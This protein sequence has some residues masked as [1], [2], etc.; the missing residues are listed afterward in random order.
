MRTMRNL[1]TKSEFLNKQ[2]V[3]N[4]GLFQFLGKMFNKV[5]TQINKV[6]GGNLVEEIYQKYL[7]IIN[8]EF[9]KQAGVVLHLGAEEQL[10]PQQGQQQQQ[11]VQGQQKPEHPDQRQQQQQ[12]AQKQPE[13]QNAGY[14]FYDVDML[15]EAVGDSTDSAPI[16]QQQQEQGVGEQKPP[17]GE[18]KPEKEKPADANTKMSVAT[19][20]QKQQALQKILDLY[21][22]KALKEMDLVLQKMGGAEKNPKLKIVIDNKKDQFKLDYLNAEI[23]FLEKSG[24]K[25]TAN[26]IAVERNKLAKSLDTRWN[27]NVPAGTETQAEIDINGKKIKLNTPYQYNAGGVSKTIMITGKSN[28]PQKV[29]AKFVS[30]DP[31]FGGKT[32]EQE[33]RGNLIKTDF[34]PIKG[35]YKYF[36]TKRNAIIDVT[37]ENDTID[38]LGRIK[39]KTENGNIL[40]PSG[41]LMSAGKKVEQKT[42]PEKQTAAVQ[43]PA[44]PAPE[45]PAAKTKQ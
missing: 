29:K 5:K 4:E 36:S 13:K 6:K 11:Q 19:L 20:K 45:Q 25:G 18:Q 8:S 27:L 9:E 31:K 40:V 44:Q 34:K 22:G 26:K 14:S 21:Q 28:D 39:V 43:T 24:D 33:F 30:N 32:I 38:K 42:A 16:K 12:T 37:V 23:K 1:Y 41:A 15:N 7:K 17:T 3:L 10:N 2:E 35:T